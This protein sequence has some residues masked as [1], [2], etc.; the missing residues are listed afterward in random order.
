MKRISIARYMEVR[1]AYGASFAYDDSAMYFLSTQS[2]MPQVWRQVRGVPWPQQITFFSD[3]VMGV[4][5][6]PTEPRLCVV[7]DEGGSERAQ[8]YLMDLEG[9]DM[10]NI[11]NDPAHIYQP[12]QFS[13][14]G[15]RLAY[16]SNRRNGRDF[17]IYVYDLE[18]DTHTCVYES[19]H[20]NYASVFHPSG[21]K[22]L[23][24][25]H[26]TNLNHDLLLLDLQTGEAE[27]LTP[28][29]GE[30]M[31]ESP[32]FSADGRTLFVATN[33][34][35]EF[36]RVAAIDV[37]SKALTWLTPDEWDCEGLSMSADKRY[38]S[39]SRNEDGTSRLY[40][41]DLAQWNGGPLDL[42]E[43]LPAL[44]DGVILTTAWNRTGRTLAISLSSPVH[45]TEI[46]T[47]DVD[48]RRV[49]QATFAS[50]SAVPQS[51]YV[52]P[53]LVH[54]PSFDGLSIPAY[55]YRPKVG[56]GKYPV[57]VYVHGGP[58]SQSRNGFNSVIQYFVNQ[59]YAVFVPNV[60]GSMGYGKTYVHLDDVR[61]RMDSVADLAK[62]VDWLIEHGD[63]KPDAIA[64]M[65]GSYGGFMVLAAVTHYPDLWAAGVDIVGIANLRTFME[66]T[67]PYRRHLRASEYGTIEE[68]GAFFDE[69]SPIH[70]VDKITAPLMVIHGANDPRVPI[71]EAEQIVEALKA[72]HHPVTYLR[73][74]DEG[75]G[76][77]KLANR[78]QA[79]GAIAAFLQEHMPVD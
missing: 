12:S 29:E 2:G 10:C 58:E 3:R 64:V 32:R 34:D 73:F 9:L 68:D 36:M 20:T 65:G 1:S 63:A 56:G 27:V 66:N 13:P 78:I 74:E 41:A 53:E 21:T 55:Y 19:G 57:V 45:A 40:V 37:A 8:L 61:K 6:S 5:A 52:A 48:G 18:K 72:R 22:L 49:E 75:H 28:H 47:L 79:Y 44:P 23:F 59:G 4:A 26:H 38:L 15:K 70:H 69:I 62:A 67:S 31:Y 39:Y 71:G 7:A 54:Y 25:R 30:A 33:R 35:S 42:L 77:V 43:G 60:R 24:S 14:D 76:V 11:T 50:I 17:D 46:W 16:H 51:T